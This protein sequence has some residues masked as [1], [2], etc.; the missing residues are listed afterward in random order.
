MSALKLTRLPGERTTITC[1]DGTEINIIY[2]SGRG[3]AALVFDA[4]E[5]YSI[6]RDNAGGKPSITIEVMRAM[7]C[8]TEE[9]AEIISEM[10]G[11]LKAGMTRHAV[12]VEFG[13]PTALEEVL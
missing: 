12:L 9:A 4:P 6:R 8:T 7:R 2:E 1:P 11:E 10:R 13:L 3:K 5:S